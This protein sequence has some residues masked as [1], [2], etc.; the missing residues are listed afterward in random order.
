MYP[1]NDPMEYAWEYCSVFP[2][3]LPFRV[4]K[5]TTIEIDDYML[6]FVENTPE[7]IKQRIVKDYT[8][9]FAKIKADEAAGIF[10]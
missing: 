1:I 2:K 6:F 9:Y 8:E 7:D 3:G 5:G 10:H 4:D